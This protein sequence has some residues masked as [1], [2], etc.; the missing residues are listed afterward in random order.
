MASSDPH[1]GGDLSDMAVT[2]TKMPNDAGDYPEVPSVP[3]DTEKA[4][5]PGQLSHNHESL[6]EM[7]ML[8]SIPQ[9]IY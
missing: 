7:L 4:E 3:N 2:G 8:F 5:N 6:I 9:S 1:K